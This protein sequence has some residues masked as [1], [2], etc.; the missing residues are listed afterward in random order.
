MIFDL[1]WRRLASVVAL[2]APL[3]AVPR[4]A[5]QAGAQRPPDLPVTRLEGRAQGAIQPPQAPQ[6]GLPSDLPVTQIDD[7]GAN[8]DGPRTVSLAISQPMALRDI[9]LLLVRGTPFSIVTDEQVGGTFVGD[10]KGLTMRQALEA[11]LFP[12]DL[13]YD[14]RGNLIRVFPRKPQTRLFNIDYVN[15][16][17]RWERGVQSAIA[18]DA[19]PSVRVTTTTDADLLDELARGVTALLSASGRMHVD[20][21]AGVVQVTDFSERLDQVGLYV[22]AVQL[23]ANRQVRIEAHVFEVALTD[24]AVSSLDWNTVAARAGAALRPAAGHGASGIRVN[25]FGAL[26]RAIGE[27]GSVSVIAAPQIVAMNNEPALMRVGTQSVY[28]AT[29]SEIEKQDKATRPPVPSSVLEGLTLVVTPQVAS[30]GIVQLQVAPTYTRKAEPQ[31][32]ARAGSMPALNV[33]EADTLVRVQDGET[34]V[35]SGFLQHRT[36]VTAGTGVAGLFGAQ[37]RVTIN[38]ELVILLTP[39]VV[40]P[41]VSAKGGTR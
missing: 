13:D 31:G 22:E 3:A 17:R 19:A 7:R 12:R 1:R 14:V 15:A 24:P 11:V 28:F 9:L 16:R 25:D 18:P 36:K 23:R 37:S 10:L 33:S 20:R 6:P 41:G 34:V 27:Q 30:D 21:T 32:S 38:T 26:M 5:A 4:L 35:L 8:L 39:T 2:V 29:A 40:T